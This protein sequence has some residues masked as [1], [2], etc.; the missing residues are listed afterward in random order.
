MKTLAF[1]VA[2]AAGVLGG[3]RA[4]CAKE[5]ENFIAFNQSYYATSKGYDWQGAVQSG[6]CTFVSQAES[7]Y[8]AHTMSPRD[9]WFAD[10]AYY[11]LSSCGAV[12]R[13]LTDVEVG[14][15][16]GI[17]TAKAPTLYSFRASIAIPTGYSIEANPR[18]GL[19]RPSLQIGMAYNGGF[20]IGA[21][22]PHYG[23]IAATL[24]AR[25]YTGYPA[26]Q[27]LSSAG[28]GYSVT[29]A[30]LVIESFFGG[31]HL[32]GGGLLTNIGINPTV[33][34]VYDSYAS[35]TSVVIKLTPALSL[36]A[37]VWNQLGGRNA[38]I[39]Q[40]YGLGFWGRF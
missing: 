9:S 4:L 39:G 15:Q 1:A 2:L 31:T 24:G 16:R 18:V 36:N 26:P 10:T 27:L 32:G 17:S 14:Y 34:A 7:V 3:E 11:T 38:G 40:N 13:G 22:H 28:A 30:L 19:G 8:V 23:F 5:P 33:S 20:H 25:V 29:P 12:T 6:G 35:A 21:K 37:N